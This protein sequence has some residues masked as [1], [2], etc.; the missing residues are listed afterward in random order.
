MGPQ[1][2]L[3]FCRLRVSVPKGLRVSCLVRDHF[4][5]FFFNSQY[6]NRYVFIVSNDLSLWKQFH[7]RQIFEVLLRFLKVK[8]IYA[9][10]V[11]Y[12]KTDVS[13]LNSFQLTLRLLMSYIYI[14]IYIYMEHLFLMFLDR[15]QRRSTVGRTPLD[16]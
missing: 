5:F 4:L 15:T 11:G 2:N 1:K 16:E 8:L 3:V 14:Y 10:S 12:K 7:A 9:F 13:E 6:F